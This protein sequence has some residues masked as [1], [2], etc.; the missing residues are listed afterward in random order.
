MLTI[1]IINEKGGTA[2]TT[3][4]VNLAAALGEKGKKV[5]LVDLDGQA[6]ASRWVGVEDDPR[7]ADALLQGGGL[8]PIE[9][10]LPGVDLAPGCGKLDSVSHELRPTQGGQLRRVLSEFEDTYDYALID[11]PPSLANRLIGNAML[12]ATEAL[13]PV[14]TSILALD[15]LRIL[16]TMLEDVRTGFGHEIRLRGVLA[17]RYDVR[18]RLSRLVLGELRRSLPG[19]V[20]STVIRECVKLRECPAAGESI[21]SYSPRGKGTRDYRAL[22]VELIEGAGSVE[23]NAPAEE[24]ELTQVEDLDETDKAAVVDFRRRASEALMQSRGRS[25][26]KNT[27]KPQ[28]QSDA[29]EVSEEDQVSEKVQHVAGDEDPSPQEPSEQEQA[30]AQEDVSAWPESAE[31]DDTTAPEES[32]ACGEPDEQE[33][34]PPI[35]VADVVVEQDWSRGTDV[36]SGTAIESEMD[37]GRNFGDSP[38]PRS[39]NEG[40][41]PAAFSEG[42]AAESFEDDDEAEPEPELDQ[43]SAEKPEPFEG[44]PLPAQDDM[45]NGLMVEDQKRLDLK[46]RSLQVCGSVAGAAMLVGVFLLARGILGNEAAQ[47]AEARDVSSYSNDVAAP[48]ETTDGRQTQSD[49][50]S[51]TEYQ[52]ATVV[53][54]EPES[55]SSDAETDVGLSEVPR[56]VSEATEPSAPRSPAPEDM[57][58]KPSA[59]DDEAPSEPVVKYREPPAGM[60]L[61]CVLQGP[62]GY[63]ALIN[64]E[65]IGV[66]ETIDGA[67]VLRISERSVEMELDGER[68]ILGFDGDADGQDSGSVAEIIEDGRD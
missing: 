59:H 42:P 38:A 16:L 61:T 9:G 53:A 10:V 34:E 48:A 25:G 68:F 63:Q 23:S 26:R 5:L 15:G 22:A 2:K 20:F 30:A 6:A 62:D 4:A 17:C 31:Q 40:A 18:T 8:E 67:K 51:R 29:D 24:V 46:K 64:N 37:T 19:R 66:G 41:S 13:V 57:E 54:D 12:A 43:E 14:E 55:T 7:L 49:Q 52:E 3:T 36:S 50:G 21:L 11:S 65:M 47:H 58:M 44:F 60:H 39:D 45:E 56:T 32:A 28:A 33:T 1:A 27:S 35:P